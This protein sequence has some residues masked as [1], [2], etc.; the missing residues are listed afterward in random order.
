MALAE[1]ELTVLLAV[2]HCGHQAYAVSVQD[3][4][5]RRSGRK[6]SSGAVYV[7]LDRL[8]RKGLVRSR[9]GEATAERGGRP[10]RYYTLSRQGL[11][12]VRAEREAMR[13]M[14]RGLAHLV[15][16]P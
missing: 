6:A 16:K 3:E 12:A 2:V 14:W 4:I 15:D 1:F 7:T 11:A 5:E 8:E 13:R 9:L 10:K